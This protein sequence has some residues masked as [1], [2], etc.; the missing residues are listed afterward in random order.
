MRFVTVGQRLRRRE[1]VAEIS[2]DELFCSRRGRGLLS[3]SSGGNQEQRNNCAR[4]EHHHIPTDSL[5]KN[6]SHR[7]SNPPANDKKNSTF[8]LS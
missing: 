1:M 4:R 6:T 2:G 7:P 8:T 5:H 3:R